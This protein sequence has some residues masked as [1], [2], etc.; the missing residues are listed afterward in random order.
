MGSAS[1]RKRRILEGG[2]ALKLLD[3]SSEVFFTSASCAG[4]LSSAADASSFTLALAE[5]AAVLRKKNSITSRASF[6]P[7]S[8]HA[9]ITHERRCWKTDKMSYKTTRGVGN[10]PVSLV[11]LR[12]GR[13][14]R[15]IMCGECDVTKLKHP[16][17]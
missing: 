9:L 1:P 8:G 16:K 7:H 15:C 2:T 4:E 3:A 12:R 17:F 6:A 10:C 14:A 11:T 5:L 13:A